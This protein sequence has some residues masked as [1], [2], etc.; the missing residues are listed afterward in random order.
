MAQPPTDHYA[1]LR[2]H[3]SADRR[4]IQQAYR[5]LAR[6]MH[7]DFGGE[8]A[9]MVRLNEAWRVLG[10]AKRRAEYDGPRLPPRRRAATGDST[11]VGFGR[12]AGSTLAEIATVDD[13]YLYWLS[14][15]PAGQVFRPEIEKIWRVRDEVLAASRPAPTDTRRRRRWGVG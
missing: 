15:T 11:V 2:V 6:R 7:P 13:D 10:D 14:R 5:S 8:P 4:T 12:Y 9:A 3:R 1:V